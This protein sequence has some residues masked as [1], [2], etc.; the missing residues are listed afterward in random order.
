MSRIRSIH[1]GLWTDEAFVTLSPMAR[2]LFMGIWNEC[3]DMGSFAWAPLTLKMRI[4]PADSA[5]AAALLEEMIAAEIVLRY[6]LAGKTYGAVRNFC[7]YQ[8]PKKPGSTHPQTDEVR[9]WVNLNARTVRDGGEPVPNQSETASELP[10]QMK[11]GGG[12]NEDCSD[13]QSSLSPQAGRGGKRLIPADWTPPPVSELPPRA[14]ACAELWTNAS[15]QTEAEGFLLYW[16][17]E[18]KMKPDWRATWA[19]RI[20]ARHS[21]VMRDQKFGNAA[22]DFAP[23]SIV[24]TDPEE[25]RAWWI[26]K[27]AF[28]RNINREDDARRCEAHA[29]AIEDEN[30]DIRRNKSASIGDVAGSILKSVRTA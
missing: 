5:D 11:D 15:Y 12:D 2:L 29:K 26:D 20:I 23:R 4:L 22:P 17:S 1:P 18:R 28:Y 25:A 30:P 14:R 24:P 19:N 8:R 9:E 27:A 16:Q 6:E 10:R 13:E 21:A 3:D 7:Q